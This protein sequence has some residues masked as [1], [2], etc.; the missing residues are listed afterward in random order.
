MGDV[1][2]LATAREQRGIRPVGKDSLPPATPA[3]PIP[4]VRRA[5]K[6]VSGFVADFS[7]AKQIRDDLIAHTTEEAREDR[8]RG[9][10]DVW[11]E[12]TCELCG[13]ETT[14]AMLESKVGLA[15]AILE[16][17]K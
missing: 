9:T 12:Y 16:A 11:F 15:E 8:Q 6:A 14:K 1:H 4:F 17:R 13:V 10:L 3:E 5:L 2:L 7:R